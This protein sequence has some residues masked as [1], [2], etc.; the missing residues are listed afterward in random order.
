MIA[1]GARSLRNGPVPT[2]RTYPRMEAETMLFPRSITALLT[3]CLLAAG[4]ATAG[5]FDEGGGQP[6]GDLS[7]ATRILS[8]TLVKTSYKGKNEGLFSDAKKSVEASCLARGSLKIDFSATM[9][10][11]AQLRDAAGQ[12]VTVYLAEE[13]LDDAK[14]DW[15]LLGVEAAAKAKAKKTKVCGPASESASEFAG[16]KVY[17]RG[18]RVGKPVDMV[19]DRDD[20]S[21]TVLLGLE[22]AVPWVD[23][24]G[25]VVLGRDCR[26]SHAKIMSNPGPMIFVYVQ[27]KDDPD[28]VVEEVYSLGISGR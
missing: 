17:S 23:D 7:A 20:W 13:R 3:G 25:S 9:A 1:A 4:P 18:Y 28:Y 21:L 26:T 11:W 8:C 14:T 5:F 19:Q 12:P 16:A 27:E 22:G 6:Q 24:T 10:Q 15:A 2:D